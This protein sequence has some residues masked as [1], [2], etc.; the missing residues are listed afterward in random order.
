MQVINHSL[1]EFITAP[2]TMVSLKNGHLKGG[3]ILSMCVS[4]TEH[5]CQLKC[6]TGPLSGHAERSRV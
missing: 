6:A 5:V 2:S 1:D 3:V 4:N